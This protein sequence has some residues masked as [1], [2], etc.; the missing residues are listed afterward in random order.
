[1]KTGGQ[2][3]MTSLSH[4]A[5]LEGNDVH[6]EEIK[7]DFKQVNMILLLYR[8]IYDFNTESLFEISIVRWLSQP[9]N[10]RDWRQCDEYKQDLCRRDN[11]IL[12][13]HWMAYGIQNRRWRAFEDEA[14][15]A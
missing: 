5:P 11:T 15:C 7:H 3:E 12:C 1:M 4:E 13:C 6:K 9:D 14:G 10:L 2:S 8:I